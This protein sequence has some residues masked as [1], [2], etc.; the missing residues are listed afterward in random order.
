M[1][2]KLE[3]KE[4]MEMPAIQLAAQSVLSI[5]GDC[6]WLSQTVLQLLS[7]SAT[8]WKIDSE[9]GDLQEDVLGDGDAWISYL[10]YSLAFESDW[11][12]EK[13]GL[14]MS[15][16]EAASLYAMDNPQ[17]VDRLSELGAAAAAVQ[18]TPGHFP[19]KFSIA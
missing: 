5:M 12:K 13:L 8:P 4:V 7:R 16:E 18:V 11:L 3:S 14:E 9:V 10:R 6:D 15:Q 19:V 17:N 1:E 2:F